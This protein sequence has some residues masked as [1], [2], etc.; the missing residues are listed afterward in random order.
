MNDRQ[1]QA[2]KRAAAIMAVYEYKREQARKRRLVAALT[3]MIGITY[4]LT[5]AHYGLGY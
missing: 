4:A 5:W 1:V 2:A 3:V